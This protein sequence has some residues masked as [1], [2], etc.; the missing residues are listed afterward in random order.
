HCDVR[1]R[2]FAAIAVSGGAFALSVRQRILRALFRSV[3][4]A[5]DAIVLFSVRAGVAGCA[6]ETGFFG[7]H[8]GLSLSAVRRVCDVCELGER[9]SVSVGLGHRSRNTRGDVSHYAAASDL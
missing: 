2:V 1:S 6:R 9:S 3:A 5:S 8:G 4:W 7:I